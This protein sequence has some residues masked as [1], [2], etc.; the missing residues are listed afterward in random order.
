MQEQELKVPVNVGQKCDLLKVLFFIRLANIHIDN[1]IIKNPDADSSIKNGTFRVNREI[2]I[3]E[4]KI[5]NITDISSWLKVELS[6]SKVWNIG[7]IVELLTRIG[8][9]EKDSTYEE[10]MALLIEAFSAIYYSQVKRKHM[11]FGKY[12]ALFKVFTDE[13]IAD[14]NNEPGQVLFKNGEIYLRTGQPEHKESDL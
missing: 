7:I 11:H 9:E 10:F 14:S 8:E 6:K 1:L 13:L 5:L 4:K 3:L 12:R 2:K